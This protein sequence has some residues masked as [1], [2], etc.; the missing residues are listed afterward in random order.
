MNNDLTPKS[1]TVAYRSPVASREL[2]SEFQTKTEELS[3][4]T[5][6]LELL[7][8]HSFTANELLAIYRS[9]WEQAGQPNITKIDVEEAQHQLSDTQKAFRSKQFSVT[10]L[11]LRLGYHQ[12]ADYVRK[13]VSHKSMPWFIVSLG[14]GTIL[15]GC[16][17]IIGIIVL[18]SLSMVFSIGAIGFFIGF[19]SIPILLNI[20]STTSLPSNIFSLTKRIRQRQNEKAIALLQLNQSTS[21]FNELTNKYN[22]IVA[23]QES[24]SEV[25]QINDRRD[26]L[27]PLEQTLRQEC[28]SLKRHLSFRNLLKHTNW[29]DL[30]GIPFE[31]FLSDIFRELGY[32]VET[33]KT[34]GDQG[35]D[36]VLN[37]NQEWIAV[38]AKGYPNSTVGNHA[39]GEVVAGM[40]HYQCSRCVVITNS[41]FTRSAKELAESN[42]CM[43]IDRYM[44]VKLIDGEIL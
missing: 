26:V 7:A 10:F 39:I 43:L 19:S 20:P 38:Q 9:K 23:Y 12:L 41:T 36:L 6:E 16:F 11:R 34:S 27:T 25:K 8:K 37:K 44:I 13:W 35:V 3:S 33:T 18:T 4:C 2:Q 32:Y 24:M 15:F 1:D 14:I 21:H 5:R 17:L 31:E 22:T 29:L 28:E 30:A 40:K 42:Q